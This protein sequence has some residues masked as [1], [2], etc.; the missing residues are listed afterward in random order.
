MVLP[1]LESDLLKIMAACTEGTL[2]D[3]E[4]KF[5]EGAACCVILASGGYPVS[6]EKGKPISGLTNGQLADEPN[7]TV[8]HSGTAITE[9]GRSS[10]TVAV[11]WV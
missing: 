3:T 1:L 11:C 2:A 5:S 7:V 10:P 6:Y 8:Y 9:D 4:V